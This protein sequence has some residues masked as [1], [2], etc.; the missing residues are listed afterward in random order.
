[1]RTGWCAGWTAGSRW[2]SASPEPA[3]DRSMQLRE[4]LSLAVA[5]LRANKLRSFLTLLGNIVG[6]MSVIAI[7]AVIQGMNHYVA[8]KI[9]DQGSNVFW[10]DKFGMIFNE[11]DFLDA[12]KRKDL[13]KEDAQAIA[14]L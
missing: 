8:S 1:R 6:V 2:I 3:E 13:T 11:D 9:A 14:E 12:L 10:I 5:A 7:V 4:S